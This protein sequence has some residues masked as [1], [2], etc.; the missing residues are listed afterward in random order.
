MR[1][2]GELRLREFTA[3]YSD[4]KS[5]IE[6]WLSEAKEANWVAPQ[7]IKRSYNSASFLADRVVIFNIKGN[8]YRLETKVS[9]KLGEVE[10]VWVGTHKDYMKRNRQLRR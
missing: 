3:M 9:Y 5:R 2:V 6:T 7:D 1:V 10:V 8:K 4:A